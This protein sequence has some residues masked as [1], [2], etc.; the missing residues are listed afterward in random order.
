MVYVG[1]SVES[2]K[3]AKAIVDG[4]EVVSNSSTSLIEKLFQWLNQ[5]VQVSTTNHE[6]VED[7]EPKIPL[8]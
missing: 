6:V 2:E 7:K 3:R 1:S 5:N 4:K 8:Y